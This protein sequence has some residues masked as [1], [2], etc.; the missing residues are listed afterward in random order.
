MRREVMKCFLL[1]MGLSCITLSV[2]GQDLFPLETVA[3]VP[4][5]NKED[6]R[7]TQARIE[8]GILINDQ[9]L[10]EEDLIDLRENDL[11]PAKVN[12]VWKIPAGVYEGITYTLIPSDLAEIRFRIKPDPTHINQTADIIV[13]VGYVDMETAL[14]AAI[15]WMLGGYSVSNLISAVSSTSDE[16]VLGVKFPIS[17]FM[18]DTDHNILLLPKGWD[19]KDLVPFKTVT[20][21][22]SQD[23]ILYRGNLGSGLIAI[24][25][26]YRLQDG[27][28]VFNKEPVMATIS[29]STSMWEDLWSGNMNLLLPMPSLE[30]LAESL[31]R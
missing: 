24:L 27:T 14:N 13:T 25:C 3:V 23:F 5:Y 20:L 10:T 8:G 30:E 31:L 9:G 26:W 18:L 15:S 29:S 16:N 19:A 17:Y 22:K 12:E 11:P 2:W 21:K 7:N 1:L 28:L 6:Q 4:P